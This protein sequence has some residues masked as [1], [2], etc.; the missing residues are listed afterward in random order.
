MILSRYNIRADGFVFTA[1]D[2]GVLQLFENAG[3]ASGWILDFPPQA[4][5]VDYTAIT[6]IH[7]VLYFHSF[8]SDRVSNRVR[9]E[10]AVYDHA[11]GVTGFSLRFQFADDF[12]LLQTTGEVVFELETADFPYDHV[13]PLLKDLHVAIETKEGTASSDLVLSV[14]ALSA[15]A[16]ADAK[17]DGNGMVNTGPG[18]EPLNNLRGLPLTG[19]WRIRVD[20]NI[21]ADAFAA[22]FS[23]DK[24]RN[25][26]FFADYTYTPRGREI[27]AEDFSSDPL[28]RFE[29]VDDD[30]ATANRPSQWSYDAAEQRIEQTSRIGS[31]GRLKPDPVK[32]A[33]YLVRRSDPGWPALA[34]LVARARISSDEPGGIGLVFRYRDEDNF[35]FFM[36]DSLGRFRLLGKKV[37]GEFQALDEPAV[38]RSAGFEVRRSYDLAVAAVGDAI[39]VYL[40]GE[41]ILSGRDGS[42]LGPGRVGFYAWRNSGARFEYLNIQPV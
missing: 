25:V 1:E 17:T 42:L 15:G 32:P 39:Q 28:A 2:E 4:N 19:R 35:H 11:E 13:E 37:D 7:L 41:E 31:P 8:Y 6:N 5:D 23:W 26:F 14:A 40:D 38:D 22:G 36:M 29:V 27:S 21:N 34:D 12:F 18:T 16:E 33:T 3:V 20:E 9:A 10:C 24:I 30:K